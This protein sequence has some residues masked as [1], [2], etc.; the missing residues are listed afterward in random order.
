MSG[1]AVIDNRPGDDQ[2]AV[3][4]V[5]QSEAQRASN[6]NAVTVDR[7]GDPEAWEKLRSLTRTM[8]VVLTDA[9]TQESLP[10][11]GE[12]L[13]VDDVEDLVRET[14]EFQHRIIEAVHAHARRTRSESLTPPVFEP[15]PK[16]ADF[17]P[18][19]DTATQRAFQT[20]NFLNR[21]WTTWLRTDEQRRRRT[22]RP[23]TNETPWMMPADMSS[24]TLASLPPGFAARVH[25]QPQV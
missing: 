6:V 19:E 1:F 10:I 11:Q 7:H 9:S 22:I 15:S 23:K 3:W 5:G 18:A 12:V 13:T 16:R 17:V 8:A 2:V 21:A 4:I 25:L 24:P 20:A 14:E